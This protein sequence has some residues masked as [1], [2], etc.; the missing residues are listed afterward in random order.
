[1]SNEI[2]DRLLA[3]FTEA[4]ETLPSAEFMQSLLARMERARRLQNMRRIALS[5]GLGILAAWIMPSVLATTAAV[6]HVV[7]DPSRPY[8]ALIISPAGWA[9]SM[10][11]GFLVLLRTGALRRR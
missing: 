6:V 2:D 11:I 9:V 3:L 7:G 1:M 10:L 8:G 4:H 5:L